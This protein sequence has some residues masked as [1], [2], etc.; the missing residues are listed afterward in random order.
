MAFITMAYGVWVKLQTQNHLA[1]CL[2]FHTI[3]TFI[4]SSLLQFPISLVCFPQERRYT[5]AYKEI[6]IL[7]MILKTGNFQS[8]K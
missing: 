4:A 5:Q 8:A 6:L 1:N 7:W 2:W 3:E